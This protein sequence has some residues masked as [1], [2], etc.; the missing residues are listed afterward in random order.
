MKNTLAF[1][2]VGIP[3]K[4]NIVQNVEN[5]MTPAGF[6]NLVTSFGIQFKL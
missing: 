1:V 2:Y 3:F 4:R 5:N 6:A